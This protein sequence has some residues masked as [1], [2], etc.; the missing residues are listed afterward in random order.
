[1]PRFSEAARGPVQGRLTVSF[2]DGTQRTFASEHAAE[3]EVA[4]HFTIHH[5][6]G[7]FYAEA[8]AP[9]PPASTPAPPSAETPRVLEAPA[10]T[11]ATE[12]A[13]GSVKPK[14]RG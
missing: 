11:P 7:G 10:G 8:V 12:P 9:S 14:R 3:A 6:R 2:P 5:R 1:M 13:P 4:G